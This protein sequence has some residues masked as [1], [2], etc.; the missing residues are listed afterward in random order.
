ML[1]ECCTYQESDTR[2]YRH[3]ASPIDSQRGRKKTKMKIMDGRIF[4]FDSVTLIE[5]ALND[6]WRERR[7]CRSWLRRWTCQMATPQ[8][9]LSPD[10]VF[11]FFLLQRGP[12]INYARNFF[13]FTLWWFRQV[14]AGRGVGGSDGTPRAILLSM[15]RM[16]QRVGT[17]SRPSLRCISIK[18]TNLH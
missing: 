2:S 10:R 1:I 18:G 6:L 15:G 9:Y 8:S 13:V 7:I 12:H 11:L 5:G 17:S 16:I 4:Y 14:F 3:I